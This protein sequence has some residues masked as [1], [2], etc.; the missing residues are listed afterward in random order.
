[1]KISD[2]MIA[3]LA[4]LVAIGGVVQ[5]AILL[6]Y[7]VEKAERAQEMI[8]REFKEEK[9]KSDLVREGLIRIEEQVKAVRTTVESMDRRQR[10]SAANQ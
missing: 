6:P 3:M 4:G 2:R 1:M 5:A 9:V 10:V 8:E 7:R